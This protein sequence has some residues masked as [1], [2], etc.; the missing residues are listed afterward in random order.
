MSIEIKMP[1][2]GQTSDEVRLIKWL[3]KDGDTVK[4]GQ[5]LC[6]VE[7]DKVVMELE[8]VESGIVSKL[9]SKPDSQIS[10]GEVIALIEQRFTEAPSKPSYEFLAKGLDGGVV[11]IDRGKEKDETSISRKTEILPDFKIFLEI[12]KVTILDDIRKRKI[13][14]EIGTQKAIGMYKRMLEI[15]EFEEAIKLLFLEGKMPG[16]IH[17]YIGQEACAVGVC[18]A[19][20]NKD[21]IA[22]THRPHGH[23]IARGIPLKEI[24]AELYGKT[25]GCC[26]GK[27]GSMHIGDLDRGML[28]AIA[29]VG[30]N[31]PIVGGMALAFKLKKEPRVAISF[32]GDGAS[33][34]GAFHEA[35]NMAA[36]YEVPAVFVCENNEYAASTSIKLTSKLKNIAEKVCAYGMRGDIGD[37]MDVLDVYNRSKKALDLA[38]SGNGPSLL[39]LKTFRLCGHSRRDPCNYMT[40]EERQYWATRD[41]ILLFERFLIKE[42]ILTS[43]S[44][45]EIK[46]Q[47][48]IEIEEAIMF[49]QNSPDPKPEDTYENLY[50][51]MEVPR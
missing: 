15:R 38:R 31:L 4:R 13:L 8:S 29:I 43:V 50:I 16:T 1:Q 12:S 32:F 18:S 35:L 5:S 41:P 2:L 3:V 30:G 39:E 21:V 47:V 49:G 51:N 42:R 44:I 11:A 7:T 46:S 10:T 24:M 28:P 40:K 6:E 9:I 25:T 14:S 17:Q 34:E 33:N 45:K 48:G 23:A 37:G 19:L 36:I 22:S 26:K 20:E 27:G